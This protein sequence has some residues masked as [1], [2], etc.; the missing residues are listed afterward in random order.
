MLTLKDKIVLLIDLLFITLDD[1]TDSCWFHPE[2]ALWSSFEDYPKPN[3]VK[4]TVSRLLKEKKIEKRGGPEATYYRLTPL[5]RELAKT[6]FFSKNQG[7]KRWLGSWQ[8]VVYDIPETKKVERNFLR[9]K[10]KELGFGY[11][12]KSTWVSPFDVN[13]E[14]R[15]FLTGHNFIGRVSVL[16]ARQ[17][18]GITD[19]EVAAS[20]WP[21][22]LLSDEYKKLITDWKDY[23]NKHKTGSREL[24]TSAQRLLMEYLEIRKTDPHLPTELLP[25][26]WPQEKVDKV[27]RE[28]LLTL[29]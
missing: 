5:G 11:W 24:R 25:T 10:L 18:Y 6:P 23:Q 15:R 8:I 4:T 27:V 14:L 7:P 19:K 12:Q 26:G 16:E 17:L 13:R 22:K 28:C 21:L 9:R 2:R 29:S 1:A 20:A 3:S